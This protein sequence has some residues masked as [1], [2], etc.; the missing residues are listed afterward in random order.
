MSRPIETKVYSATAGAVGGLVAANLVSWTLGAY[1]FHGDVPGP[2]EAV[3]QYAVPALSTFF[4]GYWAKHT[5]RPDLQPPTP[6]EPSEEEW[7]QAAAALAD[8][9]PGAHARDGVPRPGSDRETPVSELGDP[10]PS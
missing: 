4:A 6:P 5:A 7:E 8:D 9:Q 10:G 2:V 1:V 3:V